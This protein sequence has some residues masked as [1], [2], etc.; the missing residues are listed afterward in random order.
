MS[1]AAP[2]TT[3]P[4]ADAPAIPAGNLG[5]WTE[6]ESQA[7]QD[8]ANYEP[9]WALC[10]AF[11][12]NNQWVG[13]HKDEKRVVRLAN[14]DNR[15]RHTVNVLTPY[16]WTIAGEIMADDYHPDIRFRRDD[17]E[18]QAYARQ[19]QSAITYAADEEIKSEQQ[20]LRAVM[21]MLCY[22]I[23]GL[24]C[25]SDYDFA[26]GALYHLPVPREPYTPQNV[27]APQTYQPGQPIRDLEAA[28]SYVAESYAQGQDVEWQPE[29][30][31]KVR[32]KRYGPLNMLVPPGIENEDEFPWII[33][34]EPVSI[35]RLQLRYREKAKGLQEEALKLSTVGALQDPVTNISG[36]PQ[37][38]R[39]R[40][41]VMLKIGYELPS[42]DHPM[43]RT[44]IWAN[45]KELEAKDE[46]PYKCKG[47][48][49]IGLALLKY[50]PVEGRFWPLGVVEPGIGAQIQRNRARSQSIELKDRAGLG[51]IFYWEGSLSEAAKPKGIPAEMIPVRQ[52]MEFPKET[53]GVGPGPW[54]LAESEIN[55]RDLDRIMGLGGA[56]Q[57]QPLPGIAAYSAYAFLAERDARRIGPV[58]KALRLNLAELWK[59]TTY[60]IR[61]TW[62]VN[63]EIVISGEEHMMDAFIFNASKLPPDVYVKVGTGAPLPSNQ[64]AEVQKIFDIFDRSIASGQVLPLDWLYQSLTNGKAQPLPKRE[65]QVQL[66]KAKYENMLLARGIPVPVAPYDND[67]LHVQE[68]RN[69]EASYQLIPGMDHALANLEIHIAAHMQSAE[70]KSQQLIGSGPGDVA[71]QGGQ[72]NPGGFGP[73]AAALAQLGQ[74]GQQ[75]LPVQ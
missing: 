72:P 31:G 30:E 4:N 24:R 68:H 33:F 61:E 7:R 10:Q 8:R 52:G 71:A 44:F 74:G 14:P 54:L 27:E 28:R 18:S 43:G 69:A 21:T 39:V 55:D 5:M 45:G 62:P 64:A 25:Y 63:K 11:L 56:S 41:H 49:K 13:W 57:G 37:S 65:Q 19:T 42:G 67:E 70:Q 58:I 26:G 32:W 38:G 60:A 22:G 51:R 9:A 16:V 6:R 17:Y 40:E 36:P 20:V 47:E 2:A 53:Q 73:Q 23:S 12:A 50:H 34:E 59:I 75:P 35:A 46:L 3:L 1:A 15:E 29:Y 66:D 48:P